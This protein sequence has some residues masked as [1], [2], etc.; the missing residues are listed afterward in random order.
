MSNIA[1]LLAVAFSAFTIGVVINNITLPDAYSQGFAAGYKQGKVDAL[2]PRAT[3]HELEEVC[4]SMWVGQ[5]I[6]EK[7]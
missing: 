7:K 2:A 4:L 3:N 1:Q 5:Q 6:R